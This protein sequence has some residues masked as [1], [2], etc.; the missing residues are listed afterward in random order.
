MF[1][2]VSNLIDVCSNSRIDINK[3]TYVL[4]TD[5]TEYG[6][7]KTSFGGLTWIGVKSKSVLMSL[8]YRGG[9]TCKIQYVGLFCYPF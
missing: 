8:T 4:Y 3:Y 6:F 9:V 7:I 2:H 1:S 5:K